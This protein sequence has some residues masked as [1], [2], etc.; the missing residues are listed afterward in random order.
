MRI[1]KILS[2]FRSPLYGWCHFSN[3][4]GKSKEKRRTAFAKLEHY[5]IDIELL[6]NEID[7]WKKPYH[8]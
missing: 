1:I 4:T 6:E 2:K 5:R 7:A 3:T 8:Q